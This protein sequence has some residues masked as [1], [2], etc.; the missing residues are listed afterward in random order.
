MCP[1][2]PK[3]E[4]NLWTGCS[5]LQSLLAS[6]CCNYMQLALQT[7]FPAKAIPSQAVG[8]HISGHAT[9]TCQKEVCV[10]QRARMCVCCT[11]ESFAVTLC[12]RGHLVHLLQQHTLVA[13]LLSGPELPEREH[14]EY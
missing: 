13:W 3:T 7:T 9:N 4:F 11:L 1:A 10:Q 12:W 2:V 8:R 6:V 5:S 14:G